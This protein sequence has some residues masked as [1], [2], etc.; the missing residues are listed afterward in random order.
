MV[1]VPTWYGQVKGTTAGSGET[2]LQV[3]DELRISANHAAI[4]FHHRRGGGCLGPR[5]VMTGAFVRLED[6]R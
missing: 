6:E 1:H 3:A 2:H 4:K 5:S